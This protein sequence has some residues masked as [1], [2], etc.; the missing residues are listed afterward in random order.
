MKNYDDYL[1]SKVWQTMANIITSKRFLA[2][3]KHH[4]LCPVTSELAKVGLLML[5]SLYFLFDNRDRIALGKQALSFRKSTKI[6]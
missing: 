2:L 5:I 4:W 3:C 1:K 6:I